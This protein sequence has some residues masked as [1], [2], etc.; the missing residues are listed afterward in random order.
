MMQE[1][2]GQP[3]PHAYLHITHRTFCT[4]PRATNFQMMSHFHF[5]P[6]P[7]LSICTHSWLCCQA[8]EASWLF[9]GIKWLS[10]LSMAVAGFQTK[11]G[12]CLSACPFRCCT[13]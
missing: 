1:N 5:W 4:I 7:G 13:Q 3:V 11:I 8:Q 10:L 6:A 2:V 9:P 12:D